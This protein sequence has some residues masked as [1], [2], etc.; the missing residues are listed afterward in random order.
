MCIATTGDSITVYETADNIY[1]G[2]VIET[3]TDEN[4]VYYWAVGEGDKLFTARFEDCLG[5]GSYEG[6][7]KRHIERN[8]PVCV[9]DFDDSGLD[10]DG[11]PLGLCRVCGNPNDAWEYYCTCEG[12]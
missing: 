6:R 7:K 12:R 10:A 3:L 2:T 1:S 9:E 5:N 11:F 4:G 8:K